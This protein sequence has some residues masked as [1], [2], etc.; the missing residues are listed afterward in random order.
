VLFDHQS[1][2]IVKRQVAALRRLCSGWEARLT[3]NTKADEKQTVY[4][5]DGAGDFS[6]N[7]LVTVS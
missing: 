1:I 5:R 7:L 3:R 4:L 2:D 6:P